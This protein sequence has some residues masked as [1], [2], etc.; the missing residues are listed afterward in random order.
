MPAKESVLIG[1]RHPQEVHNLV[2]Q[3]NTQT[4]PTGAPY[5]FVLQTWEEEGVSA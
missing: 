4:D 3:L 2:K 1:A 5:N